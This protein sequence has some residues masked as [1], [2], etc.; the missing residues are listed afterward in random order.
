M[1]FIENIIKTGLI[2]GN[3]KTFIRI[4]QKAGLTQNLSNGGQFTIFA[5]N[6]AA[7]SKFSPEKIENLLK[8]KDR[9]NAVLKA[10][11]ISKKIVSTSLMNVK[12]VK[13]INGKELLIT[14]TKGLRINDAN[15]IKSDIE[16]T[17][18]IIHIIDNVL[19]FK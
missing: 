6:D 9:L 7:F 10:H 15:L 18:G 14:T 19:F 8:D 1:I 13:S 4:I 5:P 3:F 12:K 11:I 2:L 17:N 16:C